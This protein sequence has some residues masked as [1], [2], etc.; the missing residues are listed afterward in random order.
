MWERLHQGFLEHS[1]ENEDIIHLK[2]MT[3]EKFIPS[4]VVIFKCSFHAEVWDVGE[5]S[6]NKKLY[7]A[8]QS[9]CGRMEKVLK[10][11][12]SGFVRVALH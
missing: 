11:Y 1:L 6:K 9:R 3:L 4:R 2:Q 8:R 12:D 7:L 5:L 10:V